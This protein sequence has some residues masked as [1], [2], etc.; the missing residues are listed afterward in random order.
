MH[1]LAVDPSCHG[2]PELSETA[3]RR[4]AGFFNVVAVGWLLFLA[5]VTGIGALLTG[6]L[7]GSALM[8]WDEKIPQTLADGRTATMNFWSQIGSWMGETITVVG[9]AV[10][11]GVILLVARRWV[12]TLLLATS[13]VVQSSVFFISQLFIS[14]DRPDVHQLDNSPPTSS[15]PSGHVAA[16]TALALSIA[17]IV[18]W[19]VRNRAVRITVWTLAILYG[20]AVALARVYRGMHHPTDV[21]VSLVLGVASVTLALIAL[22]AWVGVKS[23]Q[24]EH[25]ESY[26]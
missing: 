18:T 22:R 17:I 20:P 6:P 25:E 24:P 8:S 13:L 23:R 15:Y 11:L 5:V 9:V 2:E 26:A 21:G 12:S 1:L 16:G 10:I 7:E 4:W 3:D 14:R 19:N